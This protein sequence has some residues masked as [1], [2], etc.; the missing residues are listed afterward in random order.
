MDE[1]G[2]L[3]RRL[4]RVTRFGVKALGVLMTLV[5]LWGILDVGWSCTGA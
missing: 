1:Q 4:R 2:S 5:I 3:I